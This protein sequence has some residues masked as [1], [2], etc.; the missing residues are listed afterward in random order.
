[1]TVT[2]YG[3]D[4]RRSRPNELSGTEF[5]GLLVDF[6]AMLL[7]RCFLAERALWW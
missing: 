2:G 7:P 5:S 1:M 4:E 3:D 6:D